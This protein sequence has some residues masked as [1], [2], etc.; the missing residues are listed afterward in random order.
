M[1]QER[2]VILVVDD[3][4]ENLYLLKVLLTSHGYEVVEAQS[5]PEALERLDEQHCNLILLDIMMPGMDG[6]EVCRRIRSGGNH[7]QVP[8]I[9][10]TAKRDVESKVRGLDVGANDYLTKPFDRQEILA[11]IRSLLTIEELRGKLVQVERLAA[12]GQIAVTLNHEINN[13]LAAIAGNAELLA[14]LLK[15]APQQARD[16]LRVIQEQCRRSKQILAKAS[17]LKAATPKTYIQDTQMID[18]DDPETLS[19]AEPAPEATGDSSSV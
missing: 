4:Q 19:I 13:P 16:K 1:N 9:L 5:G 8:I 6:Y 14:H 15:D 12:I 11:R 7:S 18:L 10:L 17:E 2:K 3:Q